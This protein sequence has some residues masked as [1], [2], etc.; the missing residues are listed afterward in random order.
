MD[1]NFTH[2]YTNR[3][4]RLLTLTEIGRSQ[5]EMIYITKMRNLILFQ[6]PSEDYSYLNNKFHQHFTLFRKESGLF[7]MCLYSALSD[8]EKS[9]VPVH[10]FEPFRHWRT[11]TIDNDGHPLTQNQD[12]DEG[13]LAETMPV[14]H[15]LVA[16]ATNLSNSYCFENRDDS[17]WNFVMNNML[18]L[19][20]NFP[21]NNYFIP[22]QEFTWRRLYDANHTLFSCEYHDFT[23]YFKKETPRQKPVKV[24]KE[25]MGRQIG[26]TFKEKAVLQTIA[27]PYYYIL[28]HQDETEYSNFEA[29]H[30]II[31]H[32]L[33]YRAFRFLTQLHIAVKRYA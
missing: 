32:R 25:I 27:S 23:V 21:L 1:R 12:R 14:D 19:S 10:N 6:I 30:Q 22:M 8:V 26:N 9:H 5:D 28:P 15:F 13:V 2:R 11:I 24:F 16:T 17:Y 20:G 3:V 7:Y 4:S 29:D 31:P 18:N 33:D